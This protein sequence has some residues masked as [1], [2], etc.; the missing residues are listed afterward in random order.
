M[1]G[2]FNLGFDLGGQ[3]LREWSEC[4]RVNGVNQ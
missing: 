2:M 1:A 3:Y 4:V